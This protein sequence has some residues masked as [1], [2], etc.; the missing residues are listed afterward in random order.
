MI[1]KIYPLLLVVAA[2]MAATAVI[3]SHDGDTL[4][5]MQELDLFLYTPHFLQQQATQAGGLL[6][7]VGSYFT[8]FCYHPLTGALLLTA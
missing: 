2:M 6:S 8:Q 1:R 7:Y 5:R 4:F 3:V